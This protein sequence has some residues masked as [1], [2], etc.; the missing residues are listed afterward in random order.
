MPPMRIDGSQ[1]EGGG[2]IVRTA[3]ALAAR[4]GT[5]IE[6]VNVRARRDT[7]GLRPQHVAA[8]EAVARA[9][10]GRFE[11]VEVGSKR[12][13]FHPGRVKGGS[14]KVNTGTAASTTLIVETLLTLAP[15]LP[16]PL[17]VN[18]GG[19]TDVRWSPTLE[20]LRSVLLALAERAGLAVELLD[21]RAAFYPKGGGRIRALVPPCDAPAW[22]GVLEDRGPLE[23][24]E[25]TVR[26]AQLPEHVP[27]RILASLEEHLARAGYEALTYVDRVEAKSPGV[28][29]DAIARFEETVLGA[30]AVGEKGLPSEVVGERC[31]KR[32][33]AELESPATVDVHAAD[34]LVPL[35]LGRVEGGYIVRELTS[36]LETNARLCERFLDGSVT[37]EDR[38]GGGVEVRFERGGDAG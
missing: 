28:V 4:T 25:A 33:L 5:P 26:V 20:H 3:A 32:L 14:V 1:G 24:M 16:T 9:C 12:F 27:E 13:V 29:V 34:Q 19:G 30:N 10:R 21:S 36:H 11:D 23:R 22:E 35:M 18:A 2:Q 37:L 17:T 15:V 38:A 31:A 7:T 6:V 8:L